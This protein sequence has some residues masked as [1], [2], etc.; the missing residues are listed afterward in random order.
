LVEDRAP[1]TR[2][3]LGDMGYDV[4]WVWEKLLPRGFL[5]VTPPNPVRKKPAPLNR[6]LHRLPNRVQRLVNR[7]KQFRAVVTRHDKI[8]ESY[9][10]FVHFAASRF[11]IR[12]VHSA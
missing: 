1:G 4:D 9:L 8:A 11:W 5:P 10:A 3:L 2:C 6:E 12:F 7:L